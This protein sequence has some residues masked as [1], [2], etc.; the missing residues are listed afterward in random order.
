[1]YGHSRASCALT[2]GSRYLVRAYSPACGSS[3][4]IWATRTAPSGGA[5]RAADRTS[6]CRTVLSR[7]T[8][9]SSAWLDGLG[10]FSTRT[11]DLVRAAPRTDTCLEPESAEPTSHLPPEPTHRTRLHHPTLVT[12]VSGRFR[13]PDEL[14]RALPFPLHTASASPP[15]SE[16][17]QNSRSHTCLACPYV[18]VRRPL[19]LEPQ[20]AGGAGRRA[21]EGARPARSLGSVRAECAA[22]AA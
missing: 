11:T 12:R 2:A 8:L 10:A 7:G 19:L 17:F 14:R 21:G 4:T 1:V 22:R 18:C 3:G 15:G 16:T 13:P 5:R 6:P 9:R 20:R